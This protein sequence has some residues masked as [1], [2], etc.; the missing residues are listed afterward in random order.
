MLNKISFYALLTLIIYL[1]KSLTSVCTADI[2]PFIIGTVNQSECTLIC[3][4]GFEGQK[5]EI[6]CKNCV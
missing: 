4:D 6:P 2:S 1:K 5:C 3:N